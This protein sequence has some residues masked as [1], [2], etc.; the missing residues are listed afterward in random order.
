MTSN[1]VINLVE[2]QDLKQLFEAR[3]TQPR[4][5]EEAYL[6]LME[7]MQNHAMVTR[8][9]IQEL[10]FEAML[11]ALPE[12]VQQKNANGE[13]VFD[14]NNQ[15]VMIDIGSQF[16]Y[17]TNLIRA[18]TKF[19]NG[20]SGNQLRMWFE[21]FAPM[22]WTK[23]KNK[24]KV[25]GDYGYRK[26]SSPTAKAFDLESAF[27]RKWYSKEFSEKYSNEEIQEMVKQIKA[28]SF[29]KSMTTLLNK[30]TEAIESDSFETDEDSIKTVIIHELMLD[31]AVAYENRLKEAGIV[32]KTKEAKK[33]A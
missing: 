32:T 17:A 31:L 13:L 2:N 11:R 30:T 5:T 8:T 4:M 29:E 14:E 24:D 22:R 28:S 19:L 6:K 23:T 3:M 1:E 10:A 15:P 20:K 16:Q 21:S 12:M 18:V 26:D 9:E 33:V 27:V 25:T 7:K